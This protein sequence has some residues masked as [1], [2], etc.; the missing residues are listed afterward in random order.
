[1]ALAPWGME[2]N[3]WDMESLKGLKIP[4]LF[5]AGNKDDISGYEK[6]T[7]TIYEGVIN[8]D[9][10]LLTYENA[11]HNVAP[12]PAPIG[13]LKKGLDINEY[14]RYADSVWDQRRINNIN[15]HFITAFLGIKLKNKA[16]YLPYLDVAK[17][18]TQSQWEGFK[19]RTSVGL[20]LDYSP[21]LNLD[22]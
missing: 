7:K 10:Y 6:G 8:S 20:Q 14:L 18:K 11:R 4:T 21:C 16:E 22:R 1:M 12:N 9:R 5:I 17:I 19:P 15:Q 3:L 13:A 2:Y